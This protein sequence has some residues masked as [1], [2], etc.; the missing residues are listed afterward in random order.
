MDADQETLEF[1]SKKSLME[2][3]AS[4]DVDEFGRLIRKGVSGSDS[5]E[6]Q[7]SEKR[8]KRGRSRSRSR[9]LSRSPQGG[10]RKRRSRSLRRRDTRS[11]SHSWS[12]KR[13]R[14]KSPPSFRTNMSARRGRDQLPECLNFNRG[15]CFRGASCRFLHRDFRLQP[16]MPRRY[17]DPRKPRYLD[18]SDD[19]SLSSI[20]RNDG[21]GTAELQVE[22]SN[23]LIEAR[24]YE[25][26]VYKE[27][28][29]TRI[30]TAFLK[31]SDGKDE[32]APT[33][34]TKDAANQVSQEMNS[35]RELEPPV[36]PILLS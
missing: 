4:H 7:Y 6:S 13:G 30:G 9:S 1:H 2:K 14:S 5:D 17:Q 24:D 11:H 26:H 36:E 22:K 15:R 10:R 35:S 31:L 20:S 19:A 3:Q 8:I 28:Y 18:S 21:A 12:P 32:L 23:K 25:K 27:Q 34:E 33:S 16:Y 29:D